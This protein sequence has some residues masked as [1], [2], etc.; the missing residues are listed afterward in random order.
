MRLDKRGSMPGNS[1]CLCLNVQGMNPSLRS[2]SYYKHQQLLD[3]INIFNKS[4]IFVPFLAIVETWLKD[5]ISDAQLTISDYNIY[6]ADRSSLKKNGGAML[7]IHN[8]IIINNFSSFNDDTCSAVACFS[9]TSNCIIFCIYRPPNASLQ[10][11][12]KLIN[13]IENFIKLYNVNDNLQ[14]LLFGDF[15]FPNILWG[16]NLIT[17]YVTPSQVCLKDLINKFFLSQYIHQNTRGSNILDLFLTNNPNF[18]Q[19]VNVK[20]IN[21]SDHCLVEIYTSFFPSNLGTYNPNS[22]SNIEKSQ[23]DFSKIN[24]NTTNFKQVNLK[25]SKIDWQQ[26]FSGPIKDIPNIFNHTVFQALLEHSSL[27]K[28]LSSKAKSKTHFTRVRS[29]IN[30]KIKKYKN[31]ISFSNCQGTKKEK[32]LNNLEKLKKEK[33]L[34]FLQHKLFLENKAVSRIKTNSKFFYQYANSFRKVTSNPNILQ[35][36]S[37][38]LITDKKEIADLLQTQFKSVFSNP[39]NNSIQKSFPQITN[40]LHP[41]TDL[42]FDK[43]DIIKAINQIKLSS[44][45]PKFEIPARVFKECKYSISTPLHILWSRSFE[46]G[47]IP[48]IYKNQ[49]IIPIF[50]KGLKTKAE[51]WRG[52]VLTSHSIKIFE[53]VIRDKLYNYFE[54]NLLINPNQHGFRQQ[55]SCATQLLSHTSFIFSNLVEGNDVDCI[56]IDYAKAFDKV[57]HSI[58]LNKLKSY[59]VTKKYLKWIE[60]FLTNRFQTV[61]NNGFCSYTTPVLSGVPQGS[62][63]GPL[64]FIIYINDLQNVIS[65]GTKMFT[66]ADDTKLVSKI[67]S[68]YDALLLQKNLDLV[69]KWSKINNMELNINK[70]EHINHKSITHNKNLNMLDNLPFSM[71]IFN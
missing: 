32:F 57:D 4:H 6:R 7:Y 66:F 71:N 64:L 62:V 8:T 19:H 69:K 50:K 35:N 26:L 1:V 15:N 38:N 24:L 39:N 60:C 42:S 29:I 51:N 11:F 36:E 48:Q 70:F 44:S 30:R 68:I 43:N 37:G 16:E 67:S 52:I 12:K 47:Q 41:L 59:G 61:H 58:L 28:P 2:K 20:D 25:L 22:L 3:E 23:L 55:R 18:V 5:Y 27:H 53:R 40:I 49:L 54:S 56:Y 65:G 10:S 14:L 63:L 13:F 17:E 34:S 33:Q 46:S 31:L 21:Y 9:S 45:C